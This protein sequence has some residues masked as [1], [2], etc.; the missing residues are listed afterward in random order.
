MATQKQIIVFI[1]PD[2]FASLLGNDTP[3]WYFLDDTNLDNG[4]KVAYVNID[5][6]PEAD[7]YD[8]IKAKSASIILVPDSLPNFVYFP[9]VPF[10]VL[11]HGETD[12]TTRVQRLR[13]ISS[14]F[15]GDEQSQ[16]ELNTPYQKIAD[17]INKENNVTFED[18]YSE[19]SEFDRTFENLLQPFSGTSPFDITS[20]DNTNL[21]EAKKKLHQY[22]DTLIQQNT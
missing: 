5:K 9:E 4:N 22:V 18:I 15:Q 8:V 19:I 7:Y 14:Y 21:K 17:L 20:P 11:W 12:E 2:K 3:D 10:K 1:N 6:K 13:E 16:E